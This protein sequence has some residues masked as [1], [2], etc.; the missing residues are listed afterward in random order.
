MIRAIMGASVFLT[1]VN[2][3]FFTVFPAINKMANILNAEGGSLT[4]G[5][6]TVGA[7][8]SDIWLDLMVL[9]DVLYICVI[10]YL[11]ARAH[12]D[13]PDMGGIFSI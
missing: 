6:L 11:F 13:E 10:V 5:T 9:V 8:I 3:V 1:V 4:V 12:K 7:F 2:V